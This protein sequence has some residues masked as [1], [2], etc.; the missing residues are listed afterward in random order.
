MVTL[1]PI[2]D[3]LEFEQIYSDYNQLITRGRDIDELYN[4]S[5]KDKLK[6]LGIIIHKSPAVEKIVEKSFDEL[7]G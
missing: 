6:K 5:S 1:Q 2:S 3:T 7:I 4:K